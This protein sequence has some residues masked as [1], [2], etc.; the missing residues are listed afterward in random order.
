MTSMYGRLCTRKM[1][2]D[3]THH[4]LYSHCFNASEYFKLSYDITDPLSVLLFNNHSLIHLSTGE[5]TLGMFILYKT[6]SIVCVCVD[7]CTRARAC[8][9]VRV[10]AC[11]CAC[12]RACVCVCVCVCV[13]VCVHV[14]ERVCVCVCVTV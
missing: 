13:R 8:V 10:C 4:P 12:V 14:C 2:L 1:S 11:V 9:C 6:D 7:A 3:F 5:L